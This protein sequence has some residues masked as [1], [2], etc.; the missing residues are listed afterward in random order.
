MNG[1]FNNPILSS[2]KDRIVIAS[3]PD[4]TSSI[5]ISTIYKPTNNVTTLFYQKTISGFSAVPIVE[6]SPNVTKIMIF[7]FEQG[8]TD[9]SKPKTVI[10]Y[11]DYNKAEGG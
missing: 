10:L 6:F 7:G 4:N 2:Y 1:T 11:M 5:Q 3:Q 8:D 9:Q